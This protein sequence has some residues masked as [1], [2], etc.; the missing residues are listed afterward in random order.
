MENYGDYEENNQ[1]IKEDEANVVKKE[2]KYALII[3]VIVILLL[4]VVIGV[5][6][7]QPLGK[8]EIECLLYC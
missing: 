5:W 8:G 3:A 7:L 1:E 4:A 6:K 2:T